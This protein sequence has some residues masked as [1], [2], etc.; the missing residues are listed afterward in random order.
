MTVTGKVLSPVD[1]VRLADET[2]KQIT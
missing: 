2:Q 1:Q